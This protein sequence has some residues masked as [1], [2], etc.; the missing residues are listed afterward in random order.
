MKE[1]TGEFQPSL[2][3]LLDLTMLADMCGDN[4]SDGIS[5]TMGPMDGILMKVSINFAFEEV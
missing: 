2:E 3:F 4:D 1:K 5:F